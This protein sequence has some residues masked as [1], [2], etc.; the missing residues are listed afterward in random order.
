MVPLRRGSGL[1]LDW[2]Q[3]SGTILAG[4][5]SR[6]IRP[7]DAHREV[8]NSVGAMENF[9]VC[10]IN[11]PCVDIQEIVT[12]S[13]SPVTSISSNPDSPSLFMAG[14]GDGR[15]QLFDRRLDSEDCVV[16]S[17]SGHRD[18]VQ[19]VR[20]Q[21]GSLKDFVS[22]RCVLAIPLNVI[23]SD[24]EKPGRRGEVVGCRIRFFHGKLACLLRT[25]I[26][27]RCSRAEF[28]IRCVS[29]LMCLTTSVWYLSLS[30]YVQIGV[31]HPESLE[32]TKHSGAL[33]ARFTS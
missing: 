6:L 29:G 16:R 9:R 23:I 2:I 1:I 17:Y 3:S 24:Y 13:E 30:R 15:I 32:T 22:A 26:F 25:T 8:A 5:D 7:W 19:G 14:F 27:I 21:K 33:P 10:H 18:W 11:N 4:G 28:S 12:Q 20:W 31:N